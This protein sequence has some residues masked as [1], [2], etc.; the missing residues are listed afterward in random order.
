MTLP[1]HCRRCRPDRTALLLQPQAMDEDQDGDKVEW[2]KVFEE[3]REYNQGGYSCKPR[4][5][6]AA[7]DVLLAESCLQRTG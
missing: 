6:P 3:D 4:C 1:H 5:S 2:K 7:T